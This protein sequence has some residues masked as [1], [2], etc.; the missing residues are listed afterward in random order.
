MLKS[1]GFHLTRRKM[2]KRSAPG[3][4]SLVYPVTQK[5]LK[6]MNHLFKSQYYELLRCPHDAASVMQASAAHSMNS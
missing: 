6:R 5:N 1:A 3:R 4:N 2:A